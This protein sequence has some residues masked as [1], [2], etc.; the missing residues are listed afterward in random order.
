MVVLENEQI[1]IQAF[2]IDQ[3]QEGREPLDNFITNVDF[4]E[5]ETGLDFFADLPGVL[6]EHLESAVPPNIWKI[7]ERFMSD[8]PNGCLADLN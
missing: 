7:D 3:Q 6:E 2:L 5:D 1:R 4:V 8:I